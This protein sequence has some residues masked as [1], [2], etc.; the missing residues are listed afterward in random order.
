MA[1]VCPVASVTGVPVSMQP[2]AICSRGIAIEVLV[3]PLTALLIV[4]QLGLP[5]ISTL[6]ASAKV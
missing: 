3:L 5:A 1:A 2:A 6:T 4:P